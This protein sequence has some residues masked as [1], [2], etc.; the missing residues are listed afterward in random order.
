MMVRAEAT[1]EGFKVKKSFSKNAA[2]V[3]NIPKT[4]TFIKLSLVILLK[5]ERETCKFSYL[6]H[7]FTEIPASQRVHS[8]FYSSVS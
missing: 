1:G 3:A 8:V 5:K 2:C 6:F 4:I 7:I